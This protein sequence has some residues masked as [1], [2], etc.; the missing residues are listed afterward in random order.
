MKQ[1]YAYDQIDGRAVP[2][3][4]LTSDR[5]LE[6]TYKGTVHVEAGT[7]HMNGILQ[8]TLDVQCGAI[9]IITG[10]QR[11]TVSISSGARV[12][13]SGAI[14]GTVSLE[15]GANL[16]IEETGKLAGTLANDGLVI[17]RGVFGGARSGSGRLNIEG[18]GY[19]KTPVLRDG[20]HYYEW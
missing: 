1:R 10:D 4:V 17:L 19:I 11:G 15:A 9:V 8:G 20:I 3:L 16:V 12:I 18:K 2:S 6:G 14:H 13:A 5:I 7:L